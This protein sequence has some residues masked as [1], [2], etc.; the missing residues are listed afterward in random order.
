MF[1][2]LICSGCSFT[3]GYKLENIELAWPHLLGKKLNL[4]TINLAKQ[5]M[6]NEHVFNTIIDSDL[7]DA[8]VVVCLTD[9]SRIEFIHAKS[10]D[11]FATLKN[12][13][14]INRN[15]SNIFYEDFY[16]DEYYF[17]RFCRNLKLFETYM[18]YHNITYY[19]FDAWSQGKKVTNPSS[20]YLWHGQKDMSYIVHPH[21]LPDGHPNETAHEI[22]AETL[23][24][25]ILDKSR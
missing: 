14:P 5:G 19:M 4:P 8:L 22:M 6:G 1:Q 2:K 18:K 20:N 9:Y 17:N 16:D 13:P 25:I 10:R 15:F 21:K 7:T 23:Y 12:Q 3:S 24:K 11:T